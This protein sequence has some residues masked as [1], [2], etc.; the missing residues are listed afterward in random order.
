[1][2]TRSSHGSGRAEFPHPALQIMDSLRVGF[3]LVS[4]GRGT[5][6]DDCVSG[7]CLASSAIRP[8]FVDTVPS[9]CALAMFPPNGSVIRPPLPS[10]GS[11]RRDFPR[12]RGTM[13]DSDAPRPFRPRFVVFAWPYQHL[14]PALRLSCRAGPPTRQ[15]WGFFSGG[16]PS[17]FGC[18]GVGASQ[19]P[20][21]SPPV[22]MPCS[23]TP[24][25][26]PAPDRLRC[27]DA[28]FWI[29]HAIGSHDV[30]LSRL[31]HTA[32]SLA[33]YASQCGLPRHHARLASGCRPALPGRIGY[34]PGPL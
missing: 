26:S 3:R 4:A 30:K 11:S 10:T 25:G 32:C 12:F 27:R 18:G 21:G 7:C 5:P 34:L 8:R 33:V 14:R 16:P 24:V 9:S 29:I 20:G 13:G 6:E 22:N 15:A 2:P 19:V 17:G 28:A 31:R 1:M 23:W